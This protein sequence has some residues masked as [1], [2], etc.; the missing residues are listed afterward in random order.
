M[1]TSTETYLPIPKKT[2]INEVIALESEIKALKEKISIY[3]RAHQLNKN[4]KP[5]PLSEE[6]KKKIYEEKKLEEYIKRKEA[7]EKEIM[8]LK[9]EQEELLKKKEYI[10][11]RNKIE[12]KI[13]K[14]IK[15]MNDTYELECKLYEASLN[16]P[17]LSSIKLRKPI[18]PPQTL[19]EYY[20]YKNK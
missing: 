8:I 7:K 17:N 20:V 11:Y 13:K 1:S 12:N 4:Q 15:Q 9:K 2:Y 18:R 19:E 10:E 5:K 3:E 6:E 14:E 16:N